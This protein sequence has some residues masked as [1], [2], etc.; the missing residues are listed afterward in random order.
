M[1]APIS[2]IIP[3]LN[4]AAGLPDC[5]NALAEGLRAGLIRELILSD[6]GSCD[7]TLRIAA[8]AGA[9]IVTGPPSRGGQ[10]RRGAARAQGAWLLFLHADT[11]L[12]PGWAEVVPAALARPGACHFRLRYD[13]VGPGPAI[14]ACWA[15]L[16]SRLFGLPY[17]DQGLLIDRASYDAAGGMPDLPL[18]E[19]VAL[20]RALPAMRVLPADAVTSFD[21]YRRQGWML[22][23][24]RN[25]LLLLRYGL[26]ADP[27]RLARAYRR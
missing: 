5:L 22:R 13:A 24:G 26:G 11:M 25:L 10:M 6:G 12:A 2:V 16:R 3:T 9:E 1:R 4:A 23:G 14:V 17:G 27:E 19:D 15:N 21:K 20:A 8:A 18:M 7:A